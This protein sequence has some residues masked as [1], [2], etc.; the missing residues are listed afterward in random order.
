MADGAHYSGQTMDNST[1]FDLDQAIQQWREALTG[2]PAFKS[3][4]IDELETHLRDSVATLEAKGLSSHEAFWVANSRLGNNSA[5]N[6]EFEKVNVELVW[7][8]RV[9]WMVTGCLVIGAVSAFATFLGGFAT[10]GIYQLTESSNQVGP[11]S[12]V[13]NL[14]LLSGSFIFLWLSGRRNNEMVS[15][16]GNWVKTHP[17]GAAFLVFLLIAFNNAISVGMHV[18]LSKTL[19]LQLYASL[20]W[21]RWPAGLFPILAWPSVLA[22]LLVRKARKSAIQ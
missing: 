10:L 11:A 20:M 21:W 5:L 6:G 17:I 12:L 15:R 7:L 9:L 13:V 18:L 4:D 1:Q 3:G 16:A 14:V 19:P 8:N 22:W 2:S